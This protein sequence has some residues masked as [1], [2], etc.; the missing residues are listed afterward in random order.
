MN[1]G[2]G[3]LQINGGQ[4]P[5]GT[6][7]NPSHASLQRERHGSHPNGVRNSSTS[8]HN[9][10]PLSP[11]AAQSVD[12]RQFYQSRTAPSITHNPIREVYNADKPTAGQPYAF[13][14]PDMPSLEAGAH[15]SLSRRNSDHASIA[16]SVI[17]ND[18][19]YPQ[20]QLRLDEGKLW[21]S[22]RD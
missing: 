13:P 10:H 12:S 9:N 22:C 7:G 21:L 5:Y 14:D 2:F 20:G 17:T 18:S 19:K 6:H 3:N 8:A 4:S 1:N 11:L 16:S 15:P